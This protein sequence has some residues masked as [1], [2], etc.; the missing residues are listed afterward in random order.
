MW[1]FRNW[2]YQEINNVQLQFTCCSIQNVP[3]ASNLQHPLNINK[4]V[5]VYQQNIEKFILTDFRNANN[6]PTEL[7]QFTQINQFNVFNFN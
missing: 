1:K 7:N 4:C 3:F 6:Q 2:L 5:C